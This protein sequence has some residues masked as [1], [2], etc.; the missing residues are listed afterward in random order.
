MKEADE[1]EQDAHDA[2]EQLKLSDKDLILHNFK[3]IVGACELLT[4]LFCPVA[5]FSS[6]S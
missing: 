2:E 6:L 3:G 4:F 1:L 5:V